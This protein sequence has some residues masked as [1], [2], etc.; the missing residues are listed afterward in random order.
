MV[1]RYIMKRLEAKLASASK[2]KN[3]VGPRVWKLIE[4]NKKTSRYCQ[5]IYAG[6][7]AFQVKAFDVSQ[8]VVDLR[9]KKC[10]CNRW[11]LS[12]IPC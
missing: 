12:G 8:F 2:W 5:A 11:A 1:R 4:N 7:L 6:D 10:T 3:P 9:R